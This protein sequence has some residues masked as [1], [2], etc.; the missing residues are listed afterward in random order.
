MPEAQ[1]TIL[2]AILF[3][4]D[5]E[6]LLRAA[7][8]DAD[9]PFMGDFQALAEQASGVAKPKGVYMMADVEP[10]D[11]NT[12]RIGVVLFTGRV[13]AYN[14]KGLHRAF[15]AICTC[16]TE[17]E[18]WSRGLTDPLEQ[19]WADTIKEH[20]LRT[21][22]SVLRDHLTRTY[23]LGKRSMMNPGSLE[24]W[25]IDEQR[26]LFELFGGVAKRIGVT[27]TE[28][29]L[30]SPVKSVSGIWFEP[31]RGFENCQL[32]PRPNCPGR[33]VPYDPELLD[34]Y[35]G[36]ANRATILPQDLSLG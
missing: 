1:I 5:V 25:P 8:M 27:L 33:R 28:S 14:L 21:A 9:A 31:E 7:K 6:V 12:V 23:A 4:P 20:A 32:C 34:Q 13:V 11:E 16:G 30:M 17:L 10:M 24:G 18:A 19:F 3:E 2:E 15:P 26:P 29:C 22:I 36:E 35:Q